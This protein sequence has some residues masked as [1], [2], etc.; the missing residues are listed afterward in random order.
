LLILCALGAGKQPVA[1]RSIGQEQFGFA[2]REQTI[3]SFGAFADF[4][5]TE[6]KPE[7]A[8]LAKYRRLL[9]AI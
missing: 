9:V 8:A 6:A 3:S 5:A 1:Q 4:S 7:R 2:G